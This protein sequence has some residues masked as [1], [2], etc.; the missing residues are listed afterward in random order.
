MM[1]RTMAEGDEL[2]DEALGKL[3]EERT[4]RSRAAR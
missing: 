1:R 3:K 4:A 2:L